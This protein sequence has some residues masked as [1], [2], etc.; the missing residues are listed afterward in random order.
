MFMHC[1]PNKRGVQIGRWGKIMKINK[2]VFNAQYVCG[3]GEISEKLKKS[4]LFGTL[5]D[6][7][8]IMIGKCS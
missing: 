8:T 2:L 6:I 7:Y 5:E 3:W 1:V 4:R